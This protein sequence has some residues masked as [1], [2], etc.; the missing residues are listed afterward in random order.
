MAKEAHSTQKIEEAL[1]LLR[2][3]AQDKKVE[4]DELMTG[5]FS[6]LRETFTGAK[7]S[8]MDAACDLTADAER[9]GRKAART[10]EKRVH[11]DPWRIMGWTAVG[12]IF[13]GYLLGRK[14]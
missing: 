9:I 7:Q 10:I 1:E 3:A 8:M 13:F 2:N 6:D 12:A 14:E 5:K 11:K 4:I